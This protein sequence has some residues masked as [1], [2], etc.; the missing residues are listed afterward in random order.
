MRKILASLLLTLLVTPWTAHSEDNSVEKRAKEEFKKCEIATRRD[1]AQCNFGGCATILRTCY[2]AEFEFLESKAN[3]LSGEINNSE[4]LPLL[5]QFDHS[6]REITKKFDSA[7]ILENTWSGLE[8]KNSTEL[9]RYK[10]LSA[11][12]EECERK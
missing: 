5:S 10:T 8:I 12:H 4:C 11:L 7:A 3:S 1:R 2:D 6:V 9:F